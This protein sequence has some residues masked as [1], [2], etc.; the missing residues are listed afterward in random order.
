MIFRAWEGLLLFARFSIVTKT[1]VNHI[2]VNIRVRLKTAP[3]SWIAQTIGL[4]LN[5]HSLFC[6]FLAYLFD[7][8][9][10]ISFL[11][12]AILNFLDPTLILLLKLI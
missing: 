3:V 11:E 6:S 2:T 5:M 4:L 12:V 7:F 10:F 9:D 8:L 1:L